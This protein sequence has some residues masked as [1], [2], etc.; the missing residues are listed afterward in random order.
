MTEELK[1]GR[2]IRASDVRHLCGDVS[3]MWLW[4]RL[5]DEQTRD[6]T[7]PKP[8]YISKRRFWREAEVVAWL[9][10]H[11]AAAE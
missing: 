11:D 6:E 9:D 7:F 4:R 1:N 8:V 5:H 3:D 10:A 2:L